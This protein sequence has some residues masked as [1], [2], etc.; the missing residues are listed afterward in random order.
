MGWLRKDKR[1]GEE[2]RRNSASDSSGYLFR[3]SRTITGETASSHDE[4]KDGAAALQSKRLEAQRLKKHRRRLMLLLLAIAV[5]AAGILWLLFQLVA[6]VQVVSFSPAPPRMPEA[7]SYEETIQDYLRGHPLQR[8]QFMLDEDRLLRVV[9]QKHPEIAEVSLLKDQVNALGEGNFHVALRE[10][11]LGWDIG[12]GHYWVDGEGVAFQENYYGA[13]AVTVRD[14][15]GIVPETEHG[16][17]ASLRFLQFLGRVVAL[18]SQHDAGEVEEI[19]LP[20][21]LGT[22]SIEV[23]LQGREYPVRLHSDRDVAQQVEDTARVNR[24]MDERGITPH[25]VDVRVAGRAFYRD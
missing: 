11:V 14:E 17:V 8:L 21:G 24:Y 2:R 3:R 23:R 19:V 4:E 7:A 10:P 15:S 22:R 9:S 12:Q 13:P 6:R 25:Y 1:E 16:I 20:Q 5:I 18:M